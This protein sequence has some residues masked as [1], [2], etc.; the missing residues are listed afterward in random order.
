MS[1]GHAFTL[2]Q[3]CVRVVH[4]CLRS[5]ETAERGPAQA[6]L[7]VRRVSEGPPLSVEHCL[8]PAGQALL[9]EPR[10]AR[11]V[12]PVYDTLWSAIGGSPDTRPEVVLSGPEV[13][14]PSRFDVT[15]LAAGTVAAATA[16]AARLHEARTGG[17]TRPVSIDRR[18]ASAAFVSQAL[19]RPVGWTLPPTWDPIA[20]DYAAADG[21]IRLHTNYRHHRNAVESVLGPVRDHAA[22]AAAAARWSAAD[23]ETAVVAAGGAA[24]A[25]HTRASWL[26]SE[27]GIATLG[28]PLLRIDIHPGEAG[29]LPSLASG[30]ARPFD[31]VRV[32][33]L[34]RVIAG[35]VC[36]RFLAAYGAEVLRID[37]RGFAEVPSL[38][39]ETTVGKRCAMLDLRTSS[40]R[41]VFDELVRDADVLVVGLRPDALSRLGY[42]LDQLRSLNPALI[43]GLLC[44]YGWAG[45]WSGRRGFDSLVQMSSGIAAPAH[46]GHA[47]DPLPAQALD[48]GTG[49]LLAAAIGQ[50]LA[51][52]ATD[53]A[54][55][56]IR[57]SLIA[58]ANLLLAWPT[59]D[60][61]AVAE[62]GWSDADTVA[63]STL[64]GPARRV[65]T[66]GRIDG[67]EARWDIDAGLLGRDRPQWRP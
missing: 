3:L 31:G 50:A 2:V 6:G 41:A 61:A 13:V 17:P 29:P 12:A 39:P 32:L 51:A 62:P 33:D 65:P 26:A 9:P 14:L 54:A 48:H 36:T 19:L 16:A 49:Y 8:T 15:G 45:P 24:A 11:S 60:A 46:D 25:M 28:E 56:T 40:D 10:S 18:T 66:P 1:V 43:I 52:R 42:G 34:T 27:P 38:V 67:V 55:A 22:A 21:W 7:V 53:G 37:P 59:P 35:P 4:G 44:A 57:A 5:D 30:S 23:L 47:P 64:W 58:T 63:S 20:G